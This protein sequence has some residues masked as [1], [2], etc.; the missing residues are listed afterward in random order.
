[1]PFSLIWGAF[2]GCHNLESIEFRS[3][4]TNIKNG[5]NLRG[6]FPRLNVS[7]P[8]HP[9]IPAGKLVAVNYQEK[10]LQDILGRP[11]SGSKETASA[12]DDRKIREAEA[13]IRALEAKLAQTNAGKG[14]NALDTEKIEADK[15]LGVRF[16]PDNK[17]LIRVPANYPHKEYEIPNGIINIMPMAFAPECKIES[18]TI[19]GSCLTVRGRISWRNAKKI[20]VS[21]GVLMLEEMAFAGCSSL[22]EI[23]LPQSL[24]RIGRAAFGGCSSLKNIVIP[25]NVTMVD[26]AAFSGCNS[27]ETV[28]FQSLSTIV[29]G[30]MFLGGVPPQNGERKKLKI[31]APG[32][33]DIPLE[34]IMRSGPMGR[35]LSNIVT[36]PEPP[37]R[38]SSGT[39]AA[40]APAVPAVSSAVTL[41]KMN[42]EWHADWENVIEKPHRDKLLTAFNF[43]DKD[44]EQN[45]NFIKEWIRESALH[46]NG[47]YPNSLEAKESGISSES[48]SFRVE[49]LKYDAVSAVIRFK[50]AADIPQYCPILVAGRAYRWFGIAYGK[51]S[52][53]IFFN[54]SQHVIKTGISLKNDFW[55]TLAVSY[56]LNRKMVNLIINGVS[57]S[58]R[59]PADFELTVLATGKGGVS[60]AKDFSFYNFANGGAFKGQVDYVR[61]YGASIVPDSKIYSSDSGEDEEEDKRK[62]SPYVPTAVPSL[63]NW[64]KAPD[65]D[66]HIHFEKAAEEAKRKNKRL[67]VLSHR[68]K[69]FPAFMKKNDF[70]RYAKRNY[71]LLFI[72]RDGEKCPPE[73]KKHIRDVEEFLEISSSWPHTVILNPVSRQKITMISGFSDHS[74]EAIYREQL[75]KA[76]YKR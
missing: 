21:E 55:H 12:E 72:E 5:H 60:V 32:Y 54:N 36:M 10:S 43:D 49:G 42:I 58:Y 68:S 29:D 34:K 9:Y 52:L 38:T 39:P 3:L 74:N 70:L 22:Q 33:P 56:D 59:L 27:L 15:K 76:A 50:F 51:Q 46:V 41:D 8:G 14:E 45:S 65:S 26:M 28:E 75:Q 16:S 7:A 71:V 66:W 17:T 69:Y 67:L 35:P 53:N 20:T 18:I 37:P 6:L 31:S 24:T 62:V 64:Q 44:P 25:A 2:A 73:Q 19:P 61:I 48:N 13:R 47:V 4:D 1:M 63:S 40:P 57:R 11:A 23:E 30:R